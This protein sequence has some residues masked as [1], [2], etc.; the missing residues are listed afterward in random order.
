MC[1]CVFIC[2]LIDLFAPLFIH[3][4][5][6]FDSM[7]IF[8]PTHAQRFR[9]PGRRSSKTKVTGLQFVTCERSELDRRDLI[10]SHMRS[11]ALEY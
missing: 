5:I 7:S 6:M 4:F 2:L 10:Q 1:V 8:S 9:V 11:M 3:D